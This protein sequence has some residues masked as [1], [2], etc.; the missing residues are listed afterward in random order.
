MPTGL[1]GLRLIAAVLLGACLLRIWHMLLL[2]QYLDKPLLVAL[3]LSAAVAIAAYTFRIRRSGLVLLGLFAVCTFA[4]H[5]GFERAASD[6]REYFVQL[7]SVV[8]DHDLDFSNENA[9]FG[10]RGAAKMY[11]IGAAILWMPFY[12]LGHLWLKLLNLFG[13]S[14]SVDGFTNP[15]QR[16]IGIGTLVY[17]CAGLVMVWRIARDYFDEWIATMATIGVAAGTFF[18][19]YITVENS[20]THGASMFGA[21][22]F[23]YVWHRGRPRPAPDEA[24][25]V[26]AWRWWVLLGLTAGI[27]TLVR[28]QNV[29][30]AVVALSVTLWI[31]RRAGARALAGA[32]A[33]SGA[34]LLVFL[35]QLIF[36]QV[37]RGSWHSIPAADHGFSLASLHVADVLFSPNHGLLAATPLVYLT[38]LGLPFFIRRDPALATVLI[39]GFLIQIVVNGGSGDWWGGPGFGARRFDSSLLAFGIGLASLFVWLRKRPLVAPLAAL[40]VFVGVNLAVMLDMRSQA[41]RSS[42]AVTLPDMAQSIYARIGNPFSF[43]F[44]AYVAWKYDAD[45]GLYDRLKGRMYANIDIDLGE[46]GDDMF[47]GHGWLEAERDEAGSFRWMPGPLA[48]IVVPLRTP[49]HY[50]I[51]F[52]CEPVAMPNGARQSMSLIVNGVKQS[53]VALVPGLSRYEVDV[54]MAAWRV[55][56]NQLQF[57]TSDS[58]VPR[59]AGVGQDTR[60]LA[61]R[62]DTV[63]LRLIPGGTP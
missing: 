12:V 19:W 20:M 11:P 39:V 9:I 33:F 49:A 60:T 52:V 8:M 1:R 10:A 47:L 24:P 45:W 5:W 62:F 16:A 7:R 48:T 35:P 15:Y 31:L 54:P 27:M 13:G 38:V 3:W 63:R 42:E 56:L 36:W 61:V 2:R 28:W 21:T 25:A 58:V 46:P 53:S 26:P 51:D 44:N 29:M 55:N 14:Y 43:P 40:A 34:W 17:G 22:L 41:L 59:D 18:V 37:V 23:L 4:F 30:F 50:R 57:Q 32:A 6:G